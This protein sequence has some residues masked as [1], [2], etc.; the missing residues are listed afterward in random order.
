MKKKINLQVLQL[1]EAGQTNQK[2]SSD[3]KSFFHH[4]FLL[5]EISVEKNR[6]LFQVAT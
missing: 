5:C 3:S 4:V 2:K 1:L 6:L